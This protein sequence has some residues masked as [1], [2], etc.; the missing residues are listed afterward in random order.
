LTVPIGIIWNMYIL[1]SGF[2]R[3]AMYGI[4]LIIEESWVDIWKVALLD[5]SL[6]IIAV[7]FNP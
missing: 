1:I 7:A 3:L 5:A 2:D 4:A 6:L